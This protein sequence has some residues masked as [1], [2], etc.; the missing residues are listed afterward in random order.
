M[1]A[2]AAQKRYEF[3]R[4]RLR[5]VLLVRGMSD[6]I[7]HNLNEVSK[8]VSLEPLEPG[9]QRY[10]DLSAARGSRDLQKLRVYLENSARMDCFACAAFIGH[11]GSGKS[12]ELKRLEGELG[13]QFTALHLMVDNSL[14]LDCDY[15]D[16]L[17]WLVDSVVNFF[18]EQQLP[19]DAS[20]ANAVADWFADRTIDTT[21]SLK[22]EV[23]LET[24]A[25]VS[26]KAGMN[27]GVLAYSVKL[28]A[29]LKARIVGNREYRTVA[30]RKLQNYSDELILRVNELLA[31]A[32]DVLAANGRP[33]RLLIVQ[34]NLDRLRP[35]SALHLFRDNGDL[36]KQI[37][38]DCIWTVPIN[39]RLAPFGIHNIFN[40]IFSMPT[41][42]VHDR[43]G[44]KVDAGVN[45]L[46][47]LV[48]HRMEINHVFESRDVVAHLA[49]MSGGSVRDL[50]RL[51]GEAQLAAQVD[52]LN[53]INMDSAKEAVKKLRLD[54]QGLFMPG[55]TYYPLLAAVARTKQDA[56]TTA[57]ATP[58]QAED[59]RAFFAELLVNGS[60]LEY[61][62]DERWFDV[63]PVVLDI[64]A[65]RHAS[66]IAKSKKPARRK[67]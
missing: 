17:L 7:A 22:S 42:K 13:S 39:S 36:L 29:R 32:R 67:A 10:T 35:E 47:D 31:H 19:L 34:D 27:L 25:E 12:T 23:S 65:F 1:L 55:D 62:G 14:Q 51:V 4:H 64:D 61:N 18:N 46:I 52:Q 15:T 2:G 11:R 5:A 58:K 20:K 45:G 59:N 21:D 9:D 26:G 3:T 66:Q 50:L 38:A 30:R 16:L 56:V 53:V 63:H 40:N 37:A 43:H 8:A 33:A 28:L 48:G 49:R 54:F 60:I 6:Y 41:I 24:Q 44:K 57:S